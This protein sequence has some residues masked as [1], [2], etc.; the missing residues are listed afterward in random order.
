MV[1]TGGWFSIVLTTIIMILQ[2]FGM[3]DIDVSDTIGYYWL[4][5]DGDDPWAAKNPFSQLLDTTS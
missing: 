4:Y 2:D 3:I 5:R 1:M